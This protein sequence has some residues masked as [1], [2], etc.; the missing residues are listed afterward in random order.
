MEENKNKNKIFEFVL[1]GII[2]IICSFLFLSPLNRKQDVVIHISSGQSMDLIIEDLKI[3]NII[4]KNDFAFKLFIKLFS[5][6]E[7]ISGD[8]LIKKESSVWAVAW[9]LSRGDH[10]VEKIKITFR[11]GITNEGMADLLA[12]KL[13][14]FK[15]DL[16]LKEIYNKQGYLFPDTYFF[17]PFDTNDEI[18]KKFTSNFDNQIKKIETEIKE[19]NK[20]LEDIIIMASILEGEAKG[21]EDIGL[22]SGILWKRISLGMPLQ[23]DV[24]RSTYEKKG[25]PVAPL[26]NPGLM[27]INASLNP[28][29]SKY[30][31]YL[32]D[33]NGKV[34]YATSYEEHKRNINNYLK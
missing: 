29:A 3:N 10:K 32:H 6:S 17:F 13:S 25:F 9:Q 16:F 20:R 7:I 26:N 33:K 31:Y 8:Y 19:S 22:I 12:E 24:D 23:V 1:F 28:I 15:K 4:K 5:G 2:I 18:I 11:E 30:L 27:S 21:K 34:H 14:G